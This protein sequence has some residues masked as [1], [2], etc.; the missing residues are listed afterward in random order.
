VNISISGPMC[1]ATK[2]VAATTS[3]RDSE[4]EATDRRAWSASP[5]IS[6]ASAANRRPPGVNAIPR[7]L[8]TNSSSPS[9]RRSAATATDTAGSVT[10]S[11]AAAALTDP[12]RATSTKD[13]S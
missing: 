2:A 1:S 11:S 4:L 12:W 9:S 3:R 5:R 7:P 8:R 6:E 13:C 10:S